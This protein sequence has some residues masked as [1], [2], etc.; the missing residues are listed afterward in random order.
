MSAGERPSALITAAVR[1][2]AP[3]ALAAL[4]RRTNDF[5]DAEDAVQDALLAATEQW[6]RDGIP[7]EPAAWLTTV[8][9]RRWID[10]VRS[11]AARRER[12]TRAAV[13]DAEPPSAASASAEADDDLEL[14]LLCCHPALSRPAQIALSLR[15]LAGLTTR[16]IAR[17]LLV[18]PEVVGQRVSRAKATLRRQDA[19][20][21]FARVP[22]GER[23][24][25]IGAVLEVIGLIHT[26]SHSAATGDAITRPALGTEALRLA[27]RLLA[28]APEGAS[29][30]GEAM[31]LVALI[32]LTDARAPARLDPA[33]ALVPLAEQDRSR[34]NHAAIAE[35]AELVS[36][37]LTGHPLG[38]F[39]LRAAIAAVHDEAVSDAK[40]DWAQLRSLYDLLRLVDPGPVV[41]LGRLVVIGELS[42]AE[43]ALGLLE[44]ITPH[45]PPARIAAV[46]AHLLARAGRA[47]EARRAYAAAAILS[48]N[49]A[50][51]AWFLARSVD[52]RG[53][54]PDH[55]MPR[56]TTPPDR[57]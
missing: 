33:G 30:R 20:Q 51:R 29:W 44:A 52:P 11:D 50:E 21:R 37:A 16:E 19:A 41:E 34:W 32:L 40:T 22:P 4:V 35:G 28:L 15:A 8:A 55:R 14:Y 46:R 18:P 7:R 17:G 3:R 49:G 13:L 54:V 6:P 38:P 43:R 56:E 45:A 42:G 23:A 5:S 31:G 57:R 26:E 39:Q 25:R 53:P 12:E 24:G 10:A 1:S 48:G 2:A 47:D 36:T 9:T 27:R